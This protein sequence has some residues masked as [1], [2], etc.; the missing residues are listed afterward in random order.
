MSRLRTGPGTITAEIW[1][2]PSRPARERVEDLLSRMTLEEKVAQLTSIWVGDPANVAPMQGQMSATPLPLAELIRHGLG[3][4]TRVFGTRPLPPAVAR[5]TLRELQAQI[6]G[7]SR[8]G[9]PAVAHEEC[10]TGFA[11]VPLGPGQARRVTFQLHADRTAFCGRDGVRVVEPGEIRV[12]IGGAS[13]RLVLHGSFT[14]CGAERPAGPD[15]VL[16]TPVV[17]GTPQ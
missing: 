3:Q 9:I 2:G 13:D 14:L 16:D 11:R 7:A 10:L 15:R 8:F 1:R 5:S 17:I 4:V 6:A 12:A